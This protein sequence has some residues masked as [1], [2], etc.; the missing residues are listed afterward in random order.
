MTHQS[1]QDPVIIRAKLGGGYPSGIESKDNGDCCNDQHDGDGRDEF[2]ASSFDKVRYRGDAEFA[3][4]H[5][6][7]YNG[8]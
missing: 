8:M 3:R 1:N 5:Q 2:I 6:C 4:R 7:H